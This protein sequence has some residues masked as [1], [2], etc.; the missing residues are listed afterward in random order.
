MQ[1][2]K[3]TNFFYLTTMS[4]HGKHCGKMRTKQN[5]SNWKHLQSKSSISL[6]LF[7]WYGN[8]KLR[9]LC[10]E[11][12]QW[13]L[14]F[15]R[16][17]LLGKIDLEI[18]LIKLTFSKWIPFQKTNEYLSKK[19]WWG[20]KSYQKISRNT[21]WNWKLYYEQNVRTDSFEKNSLEQS[22]LL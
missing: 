16:N 21:F 14:F 10:S 8:Q 5:I 15:L 11:I 19:H 13:R 17:F 20:R 3:Y 6:D 9:K 12:S 7:Y 4:C 1:I 2:W 18:T 22:N